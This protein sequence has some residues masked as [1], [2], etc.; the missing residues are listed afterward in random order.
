MPRPSWVYED[1]RQSE[2]PHFL[3]YFLIALGALLGI[4]YYQFIPEHFTSGHLS[5]AY[6]GQ[7]IAGASLRVETSQPTTDT[8][9]IPFLR[10]TIT[11][12]ATTDTNGAYTLRN[13]P[14]DSR[15][16]IAM[17]GYI[18]QTMVLADAVGSAAFDRK[19]HPTALR[20]QIVDA[21]NG[22]PI[23][24]AFVLVGSPEQMAAARSL[25]ETVNSGALISSVTGKDGAIFLP[26]GD[27]DPTRE[28]LV[29]AP[30][31]QVMTTTFA[32][33]STLTVKLTPFQARAVYVRADTVATPGSF[34]QLLDIAD[35]TG[36]NAFV[37]EVKGDAGWVLYDSH[38]AAVQQSGAM[39]ATIGDLDA[40]LATLKQHQIYA[41]ARIVT[42]WDNPA[43]AAHPDWAIQSA[44]K[45][46]AWTDA[47]G[48]RWLDPY[49]QQAVD[50]NLAIAK[51]LVS[52]G[53]DEVQFDALSFPPGGADMSFPA[54]NGKEQSKAVQDFLLRA[55]AALAPLGGMVGADMY[56][57][58]PMASGDGGGGLDF[59][60]M[61]DY[62]DYLCPT[63]YPSS[64]G[65]GFFGFDVPDAHPGEI[66][67]RVLKKGVPR[68]ATKHA[69][70][71]PWLQGF[72]SN[73]ITYGPT[74]IKAQT[75][76]AASFGTS[77]WMLWDY[78][79]TY[80]PAALGPQ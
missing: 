51:E 66:V 76:A 1:E 16:I 35:K 58:T 24:S 47:N 73:K 21:S 31:Y 56:G 41:I 25:S 60:L 8:N 5:D 12:T 10:H 79:N 15:I 26:L 36:V 71:R 40:M 19:L 37:I 78:A 14:P 43:T 54:A 6:S 44:A 22:Q 34:D 59:D 18:S 61:A 48:D 3:A 64:F 46:A 69:K 80:D 49:N 52:R 23:P 70:L 62:A 32:A 28:I 74:E 27:L 17:D 13:L 65:K 55:Q 2:G 57:L 4:G 30:G 9:P 67:T 39:K 50:Y 42:F 33:T 20:G 29:K 11:L 7:P 75:D 45:H 53:F 38:L 77:G 63:L 72:D 68:L